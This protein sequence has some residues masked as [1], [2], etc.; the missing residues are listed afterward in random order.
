[1]RSTL[2]VPYTL[3]KGYKVSEGFKAD[4]GRLLPFGLIVRYSLFTVSYRRN[5]SLFLPEPCPHLLRLNGMQVV[6]CKP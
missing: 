6:S 1:M 4:P 5:C 2:T 3:E